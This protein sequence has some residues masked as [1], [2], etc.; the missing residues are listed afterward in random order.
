MAKYDNMDGSSGARSS[1]RA[2]GGHSGLNRSGKDSM[3]AVT[4]SA[5][6]GKSVE[7]KPGNPRTGMGVKAGKSPA[8]RMS[9][10]GNPSEAGWG[11]ARA[12]KG[13]NR[14]GAGPQGFRG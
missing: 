2:T 8:S 10:T 6:A 12:R 7:S 9:D 3:G 11:H 5:V 13:K 14:T 1:K 4:R